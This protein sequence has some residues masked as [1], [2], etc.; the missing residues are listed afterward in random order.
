MLVEGVSM[1]IACYLVL[2][3]KVMDDGMQD[4]YDSRPRR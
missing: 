1:A 4:K 3:M 2:M